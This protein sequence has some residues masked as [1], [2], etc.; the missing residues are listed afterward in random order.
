MIDLGINLLITIYYIFV[1]SKLS[2]GLKI[3][4]VE[5][6]LLT[7]Q[8]VLSVSGLLKSKNRKED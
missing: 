6:G 5:T 1:S 2:K 4:S 3:N 7:L 8:Q